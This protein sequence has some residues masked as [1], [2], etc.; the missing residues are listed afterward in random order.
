MASVTSEPLTDL[1]LRLADDPSLLE[2]YERDPRSA[3]AAAG[4]GAGEIDTALHSPEAMR[5]AVAALR[6]EALNPRASSRD[7]F[8]GPAKPRRET[9]AEIVDTIVGAVTGGARVCVVLYGHPGVFA[10][11]G[12]EAVARVRAA[13]LP[14]RM[15]PAVSALDCLLADLGIDPATTGLQT[16]EATYFFVRR[17]PVDPRATLVLLQV[18]ML[19]ESGGASTD[20][21]PGRFAVLLERL[22]ELYGPEREAVLY[23]ASPF[24]GTAPSVTAVRLGE[25]DAVAPALMATLC[26]LSGR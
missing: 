13:G 16:Y 3:L 7:R 5:A 2:A 18:G 12:H 4:L 1:F 17:P 26:V 14:A 8:Y 22:A 11:P 20:A 6:A 19:W 24:P 10:L 9:Y 25:P 21:V 23:E 15:L